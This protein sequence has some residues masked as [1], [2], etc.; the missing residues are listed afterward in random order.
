MRVRI[1]AFDWLLDQVRRYGDVLPRNI[2]AAGFTLGGV[3]VP[4]VGPQGIFKPRAL[5]GIPLSITTIPGSPYDDSLEADRLLQYR[6]RGTDPLHADNVGLRLAMQ[7][8]VPLVYFHG[9]VPGK[10]MAAWPV[11]VVADDP[12][13]LTFTVAVDD[14]DHAVL[15]PTDRV[16]EPEDDA[17]RRYV[18]SIVRVR[19]HQRSF[20]ERVLEA[21]RRQCAFCNFRHEEMLD[22]A[23]IIPDADARGEPVVRNGLALC[24]L[25]HSAFDRYFLGVRP[26]Y[27]IEVRS[28]ILAESDGPTLVHAIQALNGR[29]IFVPKEIALQPD[30][31][32][33]A[34][35]Y[36]RFREAS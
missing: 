3:R 36:D 29:R 14:A 10:Y 35:R 22:A 18:T 23:H 25:H 5:I 2:L 4:L 30:K 21:Y 16:R 15:G 34:M 19:L 33:L 11:Y 8:R 12:S 17:R 6:Y 1:A 31:D 32:L 26:D 20:R 7:R 13:R 27:V 9:I 28:D 24:T